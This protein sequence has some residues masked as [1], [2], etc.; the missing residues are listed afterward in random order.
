MKL[1]LLR[2]LNHTFV[3][4]H[5]FL[6]SDK[7]CDRV[8][9]NFEHLIQLVCFELFAYLPTKMMEIDFVWNFEKFTLQ[10]NEG[11]SF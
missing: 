9:D 1:Q 10:T 5:L 2:D 6:Y 11:K 3:N 7:P 4:G 8:F